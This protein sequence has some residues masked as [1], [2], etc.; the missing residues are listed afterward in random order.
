MSTPDPGRASE[1]LARLNPQQQEAVRHTDGPL[2]IVAGAG[3]G[4]TRV[5][6]HRIAYLVDVKGV[7]PENILAV[8][9]TNKAAQEMRTRVDGLLAGKVRTGRPLVSTFHSLCVRILRRDVERLGEGFS[10]NFTIYDSDD[11]ARVVK[12][13]MTDLHV[14]EKVLPVRAA[15]SAIS[16]AKNRGIGASEYAAQA[17]GDFGP[18]AEQRREA[19]ARVYAMYETRK[20]SANALDFDDL[21]LCTVRLLRKDRDTRDHYNERFRY[22]MVD[23]Y[24][25]TNKPQFSLIHL[26]TEKTQNL[27]VVG[28]DDQGIYAWRGADIG[29]ILSFEKHYA[30]ASVI[31][32]EQNYR[33]T[34]NILDAAGAVIKN[35]RARKGKKLWTDN[36]AG[37]KV[38]YYQAIDGD[39]EARWVAARASEALA[40]DPDARVAVLYRMN[41]QSR[42]FEEA[43]RRAGLR[44]NI[45]GGFSFYDRA[46]IKDTV[47]YLKLA[48]NRDDVVAFGRVVNTPRRGIGK[49]TLEAIDRDMKAGGAGLWQTLATMLEKRTLPQRAAQALAGFVST[50]EGLAKKADELS[51]SEVVHAAIVDSGIEASLVQESTEEAEGRLLNLEELVNAAAESE[52]QGE[53]LRDFIDH[54]ALASDTDQYDEKAQVTLM[55]MHSAKGLE[56]PVV[57][58]VG[59]E[60]G[61]CPHARS[62]D[63]ASQMEEERRLVYVAITRAEQRLSITHAMRRRLYGNE[64]PAVPSPF[65]NELPIE[66]LKDQ[67]MGSSWLSFAGSPSTRHNRDAVSA[68]TRDRTEA[69]KRT[70]N[71]AGKTFNSADSIKE[72]FAKRDGGGKSAAGSPSASDRPAVPP[73]SRPPSG[74]P[75]SSVSTRRDAPVSGPAGYPP[76]TRVKH[77][78]YGIGLLLRREG[79]GD[80][81]KLTVSFPGYGAKKFIAKFAQLEK[82]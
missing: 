51:V 42:L 17:G 16:S 74:P 18:G 79:T 75:G 37:E 78:K 80:D 54:A 30:G 69:P 25:D 41:A 81:A 59:F 46:E 56:F 39:D 35:N 82:V 68:L 31:R 50:I 65:L 13:C 10:R 36:S 67:S 32:L 63:D 9:F 21:L 40:S 24:Q 4:K 7:R 45:V 38:G 26:L 14:D 47:A 11:S 12:G 28:D 77:A 76:G 66:L 5:I 1:L 44:Y 33:S 70:S 58:I 53:T 52:E 72:F 55:T 2:L 3:S 43:C 60:D 19:I 34:Q 29:N 27:C 6:T 8:T 62:Q 73:A 23:E 61:L 64:V 57:F 48:L 22:V 20:K 71:Y 49:T 15:H